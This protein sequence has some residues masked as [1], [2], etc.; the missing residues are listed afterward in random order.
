MYRV[1]QLLAFYSGRNQAIWS[2]IEK[3]Y[4]DADPTKNKKLTSNRN[5]K[6]LQTRVNQFRGIYESNVRRFGENSRGAKTWYGKWKDAERRLQSATMGARNSLGIAQANY[7]AMQEANQMAGGGYVY[8]PQ[9]RR[10][11]G[12]WSRQWGR[13]KTAGSAIRNSW[14]N[15]NHRAAW[16]GGLGMLGG[17]AGGIAGSTLGSSDY[18]GMVWGTLGA[19]LPLFAFTGP[20]GWIA[21]AIAGVAALANELV[22]ASEKAD[23]AREAMK[24]L[25]DSLRIKNG[26]LAGDSVSN[27]SKY[28]QLMFDSNLSIND[29]LRIRISLLTLIPQ[30]YNLTILIKS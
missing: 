26:F 8:N 16:T 2:Q 15:P 17:I 21:G 11:G 5:L 1:L 12:F 6:R 20:V 14:I 13:V 18:S 29:Q 3:M 24:H 19:L 22:N 4:Q 7:A 27:M 10:T 30:H 28:Y 23:A 25:G 9:E